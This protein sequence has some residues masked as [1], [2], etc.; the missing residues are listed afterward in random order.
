[1]PA[2][3]VQPMRIGS[4]NHWFT[5][6]ACDSLCPAI[7]IERANVKMTELNRIKTIDLCEQPRSDRAT[8]NVKRMRRDCENESPSAR[9]KLPQIIEIF[10]LRDLFRGDI[11]HNYVCAEQTHLGGGNQQNAHCR[12]VGEHFLSIKHSIVQVIA[13]TR[14]PSERARSS[15]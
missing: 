6:S 5:E 1:M 7:R 3:S 11:Q 15:N 14:N 8:E 4:G 12:R 13:R 2:E 9:P 10:Q